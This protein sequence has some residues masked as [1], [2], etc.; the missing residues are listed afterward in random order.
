MR[1]KRQRKAG[2]NQAVQVGMKLSSTSVLLGYSKTLIFQDD[3]PSRS[4]NA[5]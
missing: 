5:C 4:S 1:W 3:K 2:K